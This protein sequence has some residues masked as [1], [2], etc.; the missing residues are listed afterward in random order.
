MLNAYDTDDLD[1]DGFLTGS[2]C[3]DT[4]AAI[5][6][7]PAALPGPALSK[8]A[9]KARLTWT[10]PPGS[11]TDI[12]AGLLSSLRSTGGFSG[13]ACLATA[14][15]GTTFD[16]PDANPPAGEGR[17]YLIRSTNACGDGSYGNSSLAIDPR[18]A[19][20]SGAVCD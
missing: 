5:G 13:A 17:W 9:G 2:D 6:G 8:A 15:S 12:A 16:D 19:L 3:D 14:V 18:D 7:S 4:N 11:L 1:R 10:P 20:D